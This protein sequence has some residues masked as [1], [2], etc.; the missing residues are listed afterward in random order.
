MPALVTGHRAAALLRAGLAACVLGQLGGCAT[1]PTP[2]NYPDAQYQAAQALPLGA[3][4][5]LCRV[6]LRPDELA[7]LREVPAREFVSAPAQ[8]AAGDR[9]VLQIAGDKDQLST[10]YVVAADGSVAIA[11]GLTVKAAGKDRVG[12]EADLR[13]ALLDGGIV[14]DITGNVRLLQVITSAVTVSVEGA[15]FQPGVEAV[16]TRLNEQN[17]ALVDHPAQG[18]YNDSRTLTRAVEL[19]GGLRPDAWPDTLYVVRGDRYA[20][21]DVRPALVGGVGQA[22]LPTNMQMAQGDRVIVPS[23][24]CFDVRLVRPSP[25]TAPGIRVYMSNL[26]RPANNN[27]GA[28]IGHDSTSLPYGTRFLQGL[29]SANCVGGSGFNARRSAV[30]ISRNPINGHAVVISR[31]VE[32]LVRDASRDDIDPYLMPGDAIA[33]YD[34][35]AMNVTD[36][37]GLMGSLLSP[38]VLAATLVK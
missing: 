14:R 8:L 5:P 17:L 1:M 7:S 28:A 32:D 35:K 11:P 21:L 13:R 33:C 12:F 34:S 36:V 6:P 24:G 30:L 23:S 22:E 29:V 25:V 2:T 38:A 4:Q 31:S 27:A 15:V 26:V 3:G 19:A 16:G 9:L 20:V 37:I 18:D 10:T